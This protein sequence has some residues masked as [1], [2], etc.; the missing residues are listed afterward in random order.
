VSGT[1][2]HL[3]LRPLTA[4]IYE[5][6]SST[7]LLVDDGFFSVGTH[8]YH[9]DQSSVRAIT[10]VSG[11]KISDEGHFPFG[12]QWYA[13]SAATKWFFTSYERDAESGNDYAMAREYVNRLARFSAL[14]PLSGDAGNPQSLNHYAY[15]VNDPINLSD[16]SGACPVND[17]SFNGKLDC[18]NWQGWGWA[19]FNYT[20]TFVDSYDVET[21]LPATTSTQSATYSLPIF[22]P[23]D[24]AFWNF[25]QDIPKMAAAKKTA[26]SSPFLNPKSRCASLF[27][28]VFG[29]TP[30]QF[31]AAAQ[32]I[33]W[34]YSPN[35][36]TFGTLTW[37]FI[38]GNG[39]THYINMTG[40]YALTS[41]GG[42][43]PAPVVLGPDWF[44][45]TPAEQAG[46]M[47][48]EAVHSITGM[49]DA[50]VFNTFHQYGLD[51]SEFN[52]FG[53][54]HAFTEWLIAGCP[55]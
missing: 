21:G 51:N 4:Q 14:D 35:G 39:D 2:C 6:S 46:T 18:M 23:F 54:T 44:T 50:Q 34:Y 43:K 5:P 27:Q 49:T 37:D 45:S 40:V 52:L 15:T 20:W 30:S 47:L 36:N 12:E 53:N 28:K 1:N 13:N 25:P 16:P 31:N 8:Y 17:A 11:A 24:P 7:V 26:K 48:H 9:Q 3:C 38:S 19:M 55:P 10:D 42:P 33:Q 22:L 29:L 32:G 41:L